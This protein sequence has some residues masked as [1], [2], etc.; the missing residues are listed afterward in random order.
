VV[1]E[2][3]CGAF[4]KRQS[5]SIDAHS[6]TEN[7]GGRV[8]AGANC[9]CVC[10]CEHPG[11]P[12][13]QSVRGARVPPTPPPPTPRTAHCGT[14]RAMTWVSHHTHTYLAPDVHHG[15]HVTVVVGLGVQEHHLVA[16][17][18]GVGPAGA[19]RGVVPV[20][21]G[22]EGAADEGRARRA[23]VLPKEGNRR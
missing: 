19:C 23:R 6:W 7:K 22:R 10:V 13:K 3:R 21:E 9:V 16:D 4:A 20:P 1:D 15:G 5:H 12:R 11:K 14:S 18:T 2:L 17:L 8:D